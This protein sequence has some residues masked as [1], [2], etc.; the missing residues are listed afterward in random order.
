MGGYLIPA[1]SKKS[2][3]IFG[4]FKQFDLLLFGSGIGITLVLL[5]F[6][7]IEQSILLSVLALAPAAVTGFLVLPIPNY[8]NVRMLIKTV[9][10]FYTEKRRFIWKGWCAK[11]GEQK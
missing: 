8:H 9:F 7:P 10:I 5:L 1:N 6:L 4:L 11:D 3:L 2:L